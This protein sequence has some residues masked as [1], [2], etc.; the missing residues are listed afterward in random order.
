MVFRLIQYESN[1]RKGEAANG[2]DAVKLFKQV[3]PDLVTMDLTMPEFSL[4][5]IKP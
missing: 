1:L 2:K 4:P 5:L 3:K